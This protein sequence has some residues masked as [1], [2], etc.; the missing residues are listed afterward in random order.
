MAPGHGGKVIM[1]RILVAEDSPTQALQMRRLLEAA[2][3]EVTTARD[4]LEAMQSLRADP[5]ALIVSDLQM[6]GMDGL[7]LVGAVR[8]ELPSVPIV[9]VTS[10]GSEEIAARALRAGAAS[11]VPKRNLALDLVPTLQQ[12]LAVRSAGRTKRLPPGAARQRSARFEIE[13]DPELIGPL[14]AL[15]ED[16]LVLMGLFDEAGRMHAAVALQEALS[17]ALYHGNLEVDSDLRQDDER[18]FFA[19]ARRRRGLEPYRSRS[20][21]VEAR[22]DG[23]AATFVV[24]DQGPGF[25]T[26]LMDRPPEPSDLLRVGGRGL[27]LIRTF[28]DE[29]THNPAGNRIT[30]IKRPAR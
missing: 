25:D 16:D 22:L 30:M 4:G 28:M 1:A 19:E 2:G 18:R 9:L 13:N 29:V 15:L 3:F 17:N 14:V 20:I 5:P 12:I 24:E 26:S 21:S 6:P 27:L 8:A 7:A 10:F 11:Y 23:G